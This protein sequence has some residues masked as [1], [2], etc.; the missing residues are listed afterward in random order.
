MYIYNTIANLLINAF[1]VSSRRSTVSTLSSVLSHLFSQL[2]PFEF[3]ALKLWSCRGVF[4]TVMLFYLERTYFSFQYSGLKNHHG[5]NPHPSQPLSFTPA[6]NVRL[7]GIGK[8]TVGEVSSIFNPSQS[9]T[10]GKHTI[11]CSCSDLT[12]YFDS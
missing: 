5:Y 8:Q 2:F 4:F 11:K 9:R 7:E 3:E 1:L 6:W 10:V 12:T